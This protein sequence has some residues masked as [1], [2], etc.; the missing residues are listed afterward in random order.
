MDAM[1]E[2]ALEHKAKEALSSKPTGTG[3]A[4]STPTADQRPTYETGWRAAQTNKQTNKPPRTRERQRADERVALRRL[5]F[6]E[7]C[8]VPAVM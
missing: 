2:R 6:D 1:Q 7:A 3:S 8:V 4:H 5:F